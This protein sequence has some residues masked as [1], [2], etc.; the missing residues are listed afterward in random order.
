MLIQSRVKKV[1]FLEN[2]DE[3]AFRASK[4]MLDH[5]RLPYEQIVMPQEAY[6]IEL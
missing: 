5:A 2:R 6:V 3:L 4:K 1:Y